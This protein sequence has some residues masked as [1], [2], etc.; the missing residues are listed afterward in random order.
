MSEVGG[1]SVANLGGALMVMV[2]PGK[3]SKFKNLNL[4]DFIA[5]F[6]KLYITKIDFKNILE[7]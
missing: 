5:V 1:G 6:T 7:N 4:L 2:Q 3:K